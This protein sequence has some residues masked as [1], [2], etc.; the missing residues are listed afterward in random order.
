MM[1]PEQIVAGRKAKEATLL[2]LKQRYQELVDLRAKQKSEN[3]A[4]HHIGKAEK[5]MRE[6]AIQNK[7]YLKGRIAEV[8]ELYKT[9]SGREITA[10]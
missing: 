4:R 7:A 2:I 6:Q 10:P 3:E 1:T 8:T 9:L 5:G